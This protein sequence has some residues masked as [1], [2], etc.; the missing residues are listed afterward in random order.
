MEIEKYL[1]IKKS[2][3]R[4]QQYV[5]QAYQTLQTIINL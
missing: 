2:Q 5:S 3:L 1:W 4:V